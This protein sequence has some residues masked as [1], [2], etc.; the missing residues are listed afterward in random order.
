M[1]KFTQD[2]KSGGSDIFLK[3]CS[4]IED[5]YAHLLGVHTTKVA[6]Y[7]KLVTMRENPYQIL[8]RL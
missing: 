7:P 5:F 8:C 3:C 6:N 1:I 2:F 4:G